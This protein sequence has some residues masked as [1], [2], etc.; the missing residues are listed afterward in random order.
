MLLPPYR[1][2][3]EP[4][5]SLLSNRQPTKARRKRKLQAPSFYLDAHGSLAPSSLGCPRKNVSAICTFTASPGTGIPVCHQPS[6][7]SLGPRAPR[8][9]SFNAT[10]SHLS[11]STMFQQTPPTD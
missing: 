6:P 9:L 11:D 10:L 3:V 7:L 8:P 2:P 5:E 1:L 4:T